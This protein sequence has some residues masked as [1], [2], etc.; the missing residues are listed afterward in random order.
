M[1]TFEIEAVAIAAELTALRPAK[2]TPTNILRSMMKAEGQAPS[3]WMDLPDEMYLKAVF[4]S[5]WVTPMGA[6]IPDTATNEDIAIMLRFSSAHNKS[7]FW[8]TV[9]L[10]GWMRDHKYDGRI[11]KDVLEKL[12]RQ[13]GRSYKTLA[14]YGTCA[15]VYPKAER[16]SEVSPSIYLAFAAIEDAGLRKM[17]LNEAAANNWTVMQAQEKAKEYIAI[18]ATVNEAGEL[19]QPD[20]SVLPAEGDAVISTGPTVASS[21][22]LAANIPVCIRTMVDDMVKAG[23]PNDKMA[24]VTTVLTNYVEAGKLKFPARAWHVAAVAPKRSAV[25]VAVSKPGAVLVSADDEE[26]MPF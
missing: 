8:A 1:G 2:G 19:V 23:L 25:P 9:D 13:M 18:G 20:M 7:D 22:G 26:D 12:A 14:N 10:V 6:N 16:I 11:P 15:A 5:G 3:A 17:L 21:S 4:D 24:I